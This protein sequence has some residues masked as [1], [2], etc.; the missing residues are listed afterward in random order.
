[1]WR[2]WRKLCKC[3]CGVD[4]TRLPSKSQ[5]IHLVDR[6]DV[7]SGWDNSKQFCFCA[8]LSDCR[9]GRCKRGFSRPTCVLDVPIFAVALMVLHSVDANLWCRKWALRG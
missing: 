1:M 9:F 5:P 6:L 3:F 8:N 7:I 2:I 4:L